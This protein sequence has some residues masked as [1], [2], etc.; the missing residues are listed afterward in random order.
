MAFL[1]KDSDWGALVPRLNSLQVTQAETRLRI[2]YDA[3]FK[4]NDAILAMHVSI[5]VGPES[6][7]M[8]ATGDAQGLFETN[9]AGFTGLHPIADVAGQPLCVTHSDGSRHETA[10]PDLIEPWQPFMDIVALTRQVQTAKLC[11]AMSACLRS[12]RALRL[13]RERARSRGRPFLADA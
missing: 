2:T 13:P 12:D 3:A 8:S 5:D 4:S 7:V 10:F 9:R 11:C 6:L 1:V